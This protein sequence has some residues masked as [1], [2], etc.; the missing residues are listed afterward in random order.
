MEAVFRP[1]LTLT[2]PI[3]DLSKRLV[4]TVERSWDSLDDVKFSVFHWEDNDFAFAQRK[5]GDRTVIWHRPNASWSVDV[6][7]NRI[8]QLILP[9]PEGVVWRA[10]HV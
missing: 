3:E 4:L 7:S 2:Y 10:E 1:I 6:A 8:L 9:D 5:H